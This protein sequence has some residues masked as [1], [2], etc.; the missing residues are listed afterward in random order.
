MLFGERIFGAIGQLIRDDPE[1]KAML[2]VF[3]TLLNL[4]K[5]QERG[6]GIGTTNIDRL[7]II[8]F[9]VQPKTTALAS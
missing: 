7:A 3:A 2:N 8:G 9:V 6:K 5:G 4:D 1:V